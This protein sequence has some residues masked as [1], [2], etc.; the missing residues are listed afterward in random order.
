MQLNCDSFDS[1]EIDFLKLVQ[2][3]VN[4]ADGLTK[5]NPNIFQIANRITVDGV[6]EILFYQSFKLDRTSWK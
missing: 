2:A 6:F 4:I 1:C 3:K 5:Y